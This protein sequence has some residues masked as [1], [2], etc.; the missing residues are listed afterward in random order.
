MPTNTA[1]SSSL[2]AAHLATQSLQAK[3]STQA[4]A[5]GVNAILLPLGATA[6]MSQVGAPG[7][8]FLLIVSGTLAWALTVLRMLR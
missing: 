2:V 8:W 6:A 3:E 1:C 5:A 7:L 4:L